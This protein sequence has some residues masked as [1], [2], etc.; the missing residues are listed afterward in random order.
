MKERKRFDNT[1]KINLQ[2]V[3]LNKED[4]LVGRSVVV[5]KSLEEVRDVIEKYV[6]EI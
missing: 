1:I 3:N 5:L 4:Y 6:R 2:M